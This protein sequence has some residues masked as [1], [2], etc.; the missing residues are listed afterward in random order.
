MFKN[1]RNCARQCLGC[2]MATLPRRRLARHVDVVVGV[3]RYIL[4]RHRAHGLFAGSQCDVVY[5]GCR[6]AAPAGA[7]RRSGEKLRIGFLGA[8]VPHKGI[9]RLLEAF[10]RLPPGVA[11]LRIGGAGEAAYV[12]R[13]KARA[14]GRN[15][16]GWL[17][18]VDPGKFLPQLDVLVVPSLVNEAMG[19]VVLEAFA[20]GVPVLAANRGGL[21]EL[22]DE[23]S[24]ELFDPDDV[25]SLARRLEALIAH[26]ERLDAWR[27]GARERSLGFTRE[28]MLEGYLA[29]Y[30]G[31][32]R[33]V[34]AG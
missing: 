17:G 32:R 25:P 24:G 6:A 21:P 15:D 30:E 26:P 5:G 4:E 33:A 16:V 29:A 13:L 1:G 34:S 19:R 27:A 3:S 12:E 22:V 20:A 9:E 10:L 7:P 11:E 8:L 14:R 31:A 18:F 2:R 23:G 28:A